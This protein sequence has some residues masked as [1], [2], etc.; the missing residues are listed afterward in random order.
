MLL[1][2]NTDNISSDDKRF[3]PS[4]NNMQPINQLRYFRK[5]FEPIW[6][7]NK[8]NLKCVGTI[9]GNHEYNGAAKMS[10]EDFKREYCDS[11]KD[12][13]M[14]LNYLGTMCYLRF[15][16]LW[17]GKLMRFY[18]ILAAHGR[19]KG[20]QSGGE[21]NQ[22]KR[23]P[24]SHEKFDVYLSGDS[25][26]KKTD[27]SMLQSLEVIDGQAVIAKRKVV[28]A[29]CGTFQESFTIGHQNYIEKA[30]FYSRASD[31]GTITI[32]FNPYKGSH[33]AVE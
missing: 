29:S 23:L 2:D 17:N 9:I 16:F 20:S 12:G 31:I 19:Y 13:G 3:N 30:H 4:S 18:D 25:H 32:I 22:M 5:M 1:G 10:E 21:L 24:S 11:I 6:N 26:D 7:H 33:S 8:D 28:F 15:N 27:K 14:E